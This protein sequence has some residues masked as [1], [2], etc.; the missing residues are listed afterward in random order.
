MLKYSMLFSDQVM[1]CCEN[2]VAVVASHMA[3]YALQYDSIHLLVGAAIF[4]LSLVCSK[5][6]EP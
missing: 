2:S 5:T 1:C 3:R 4:Q 6:N